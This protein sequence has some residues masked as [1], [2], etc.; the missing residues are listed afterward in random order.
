LRFSIL[1]SLA[2]V[3][4]CVLTPAAGL[5]SD[6]GSVNTA[7]VEGHVVPAY[8][9]LA[10]AAATLSSRTNAFCGTGDT[11]RPAVASDF[12][13]LR[14]TWAGA[15]HLSF[16]PSDLLM[17]GLRFNFWPQARGK[18]APA[19]EKV[20]ADR[21]GPVTDAKPVNRLSL[22]VQGLPAMDQLLN[23]DSPVESG[24]P[25]CALATQVADNLS[26]M[27]HGMLADWTTGDTSFAQTMSAPGPDNPYF[28]TQ[29]DVTLAL[30]KSL[31]EG[32]G[33][34][35]A[36]KIDPVLGASA[37]AVRPALAEGIPPGAALTIIRGNLAALQQLY[38]G[39]DGS[40]LAALA[41]QSATDPGLAPLM[42][43]AFAKTRET[44]DGIT[45]PLGVAVTDPDERIKVEKLSTQVRALTQIVGTRLGQALGLSIGFNSLDGD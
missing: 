18:V 42:D 45:L 12:E 35:S 36:L 24:S 21:E 30:F 2:A 4:L 41:R 9:R 44:A 25:R 6:Y 17:R 38:N 29:A 13:K 19:L 20:L 32:L 3:A 26:T 34:I 10:D 39:P 22:A 31:H 1:S 40:G 11:T 7:L 5:A 27:A 8:V 16:G 14:A 15:E 37:E 33:K 28:E 23:G 43:K